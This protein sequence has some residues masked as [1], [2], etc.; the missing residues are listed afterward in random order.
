MAKVLGAN[1]RTNRLLPAMEPENF[2]LLEPH[3]KVIGLFRGQ[4]LA[5]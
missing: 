4:V 1:H 3:L 5:S 2:A